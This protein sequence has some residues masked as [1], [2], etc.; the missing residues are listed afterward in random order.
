MVWF[1][2]G[3]KGLRLSLDHKASDPEEVA[4]IQAAGGFVVMNRVNGKGKEG[5][6]VWS[7]DEEMLNLVVKVFW[8]LLELLEIVL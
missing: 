2:R 4:R 1:S 7:Y 8:L 5:D 3:G 6:W